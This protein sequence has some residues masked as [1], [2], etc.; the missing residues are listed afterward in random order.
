M[1]AAPQTGGGDVL[2]SC[3]LGLFKSFI[4]LQ[5]GLFVFLLLIYKSSLCILDTHFLSDIYNMNTF[6]CLWFCLFYFLMISFLMS[7]KFKILMKSSLSYF[8]YIFHVFC[9][10]FKK[11]LFT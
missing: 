4:L 3:V 8:A 1:R 7:Q 5:I 11:T 9:V 6:L 2:G 10:S